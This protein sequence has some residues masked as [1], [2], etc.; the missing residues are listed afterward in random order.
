MLL[1]YFAATLLV[2]IPL[3]PMTDDWIDGV[4]HKSSRECGST[5]T[6]LSFIPDATPLK[7]AA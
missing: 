3:L 5:T 2:S 1:D 6:L 4:G 7:S